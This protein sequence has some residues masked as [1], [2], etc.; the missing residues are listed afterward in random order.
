MAEK[1]CNYSQIDLN[2]VTFGN[3]QFSPDS[4][5]T[6]FN[7]MKGEINF[8]QIAVFN[9]IKNWY[10]LDLIHVFSHHLVVFHPCVPEPSRWFHLLLI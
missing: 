9:V 5:Q 8:R 10:H 4:F 1:Y 7:L 3:F 6:K 2:T